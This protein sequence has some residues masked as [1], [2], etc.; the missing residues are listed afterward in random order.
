VPGR[1]IISGS[2]YPRFGVSYKKAL[3]LGINMMN[4][5]LATASIYDDLSLG[6]FGRLGYRAMGGGFLNSKKISFMDYKHFLGNQTLINTSDYL[7][8]F[9]LLPFY[10]YSTR[11]WFLEGHAEHHFNGFILNKIPLVK[12][13]IV[14]EVVGAHL[15]INDQIKRYYEINFGLENIF[16]LL[17]IDYVLGYGLNNKLKQGFTIGIN[18]RL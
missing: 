12:K 8:S 14:Q 6:L 15:L 4:F 3:P 10:T 1:K 9:R 16:G 13:L 18:T 7:N 11:Q 17:R 5:D 2:K